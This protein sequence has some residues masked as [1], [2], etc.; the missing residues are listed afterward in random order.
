MAIPSG[1]G[2]EV[3]KNTSIHGFSGSSNA[4]WAVRWDGT[5]VSAQ[6]DTYAVPANHIITV[7]NFSVCNT[8][9]TNRLLFSLVIRCLGT[10]TDK[11]ILL[12]QSVP[13][14]ETFVYSDKIILHGGDKLLF[15]D[16]TSDTGDDGDII[17]HYIDQ[18]WS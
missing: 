8:H 9:P 7:L 13:N 14:Y 5:E 11:Y 18:D 4:P 2:S 1:S 10:V 12:E 15:D 16:P 17:I 3:L 6:S